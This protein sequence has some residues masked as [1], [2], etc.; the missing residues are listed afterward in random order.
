MFV[1]VSDEGAVVVDAEV[2]GGLRTVNAREGS[3]DGGSVRQHLLSYATG[4]EGDDL[5]D[6][7]LIDVRGTLVKVEAAV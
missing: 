1:W 7:P 6:M 2:S 4:I 5:G 3:R